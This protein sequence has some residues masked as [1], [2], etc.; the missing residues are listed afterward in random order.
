MT[1]TEINRF[2]AILTETVAELGSP[3]TATGSL[4]GRAA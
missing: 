2:R 1:K 4:L 3:A